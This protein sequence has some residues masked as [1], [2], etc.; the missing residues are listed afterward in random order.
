MPSIQNAGE[1]SIIVYFGDK[2]SN[3]VSS[4]IAEFCDYIKM[5]HETYIKDLI[6]SYASV[7]VIFDPSQT[8]HLIATKIVKNAIISTQEASKKEDSHKKG[9]LVQLPVFYGGINGPDLERIANEARLTADEV[10]EIH[11]S[12]SYSVY[13]IGF[14]PGF[15]YLGEVDSKIAT[16]RIS[17]PRKLV[18]KGSVAIADKQTAV[19]PSASPGGWNIIGICPVPMFDA[20]QK[21]H[22]PLRVGDTVKFKSIDENEFN[23]LKMEFKN[24]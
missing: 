24:K 15:A 17:T 18:P 23:A 12:V 16:P 1:N 3:S 2:P 9:K 7:L 4:H 5:K 14:A 11:Q 13:A 22:V 20:F 19:Y 10:A 21:P 6:S 8:N